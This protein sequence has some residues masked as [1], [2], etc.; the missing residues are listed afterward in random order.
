MRR[1]ISS[2]C[3]VLIFSIFLAFIFSENVEK[4]KMSKFENYLYVKR[5][6]FGNCSNLQFV[7]F[8]FCSYLKN[9]QI[10]KSFCVENCSGLK[11]MFFILIWKLFQFENYFDLK[12]VPVWKL[13]QLGSCFI[14]KLF[15][16]KKCE[17]IQ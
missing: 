16:F 12:F 2:L 8:E 1:P 9:A 14:W 4:I 13:F 17:N 11:K 5:F 7:P 15:Q 10:W 6:K 3:W